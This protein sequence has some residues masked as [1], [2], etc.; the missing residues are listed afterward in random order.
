MNYI[1]EYVGL[2]YN[3]CRNKEWDNAIAIVGDEGSSKS[4]LLLHIVD[5]WYKHLR[6]ECQEKDIDHVSLDRKQW[7]GDLASLKRYDCTAY[8]EAG[9]ISNRRAM[10]KFNFSVMKA[11]Q[12]IRADNLFTVLAL[13]SLWDLDPFFR[14][15]RLRGFFYVY[16]RG[17]CAFWSKTRMRRMLDINQGRNVKRYYVVKPSFID[18][19]PIYRGVLE[20]AYA[21]KKSTKV[22]EARRELLEEDD[23]V[24]A[25]EKRDEMIIK[26][27]ENHGV[28]GTAD[29]HNMSRQA[30]YNILNKRS[31]STVK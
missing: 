27:V 25:Y 8:D 22:S 7:L 1:R 20:S 15:R 4:N 29:F 12:I 19:F 16:Q 17:R 23:G 9:D 18:S 21:D 30:I 2:V 31:V 28:T 5:T 14:N 3:F 24:D 13:P 10:S 11:Y 6:G 26:N